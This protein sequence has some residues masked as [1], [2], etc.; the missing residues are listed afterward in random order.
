MN[1][2]LNI[3]GFLSAAALLVGV[4]ACSTQKAT[5]SNIQYHNLTTHYN[6]WWNGNESMKKGVAM[7]NAKCKDDYTKLLPVYKM[8]TKEEC[9]SLYP[10]FDRAVEKSVK[11]IKKHSI[12][13]NG[14]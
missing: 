9:M 5:W 1:K 10:E 13:V 7:M 8:G 14:Q 11:G 12:F 3:I 4:A 2:K 6:I